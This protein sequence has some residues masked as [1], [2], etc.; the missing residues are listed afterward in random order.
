MS[1]AGSLAS[2]DAICSQWRS[3]SVVMATNASEIIRGKPS[4]EAVRGSAETTFHTKTAHSAAALMSAALLDIGRGF[5]K[6]Q[7]AA[8]TGQPG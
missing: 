4:G 1:K 7:Q 8:A 2:T 5:L 3:W 6:R